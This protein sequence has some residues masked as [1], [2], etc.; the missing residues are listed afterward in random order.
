MSATGRSGEPRPP[1]RVMDHIGVISGVLFG[2]GVLA[3]LVLLAVAGYPSAVAIL[4]VLVIGVGLIGIGAQ[5]R[6]GRGR[7]G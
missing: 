2:L 3:F 5:M 6:G 7:R 1:F 4:V